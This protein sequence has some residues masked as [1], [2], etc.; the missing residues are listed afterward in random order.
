MDKVYWVYKTIYP[1]KKA[2]KGS[3]LEAHFEAQ[4][5][6]AW[7]LPNGFQPQSE[8]SISSVGDLINHDYLKNSKAT[9]YAKVSDLIFGADITMANLECPIVPKANKEFV[10]SVKA[11]PPLYYDL[12]NFAVVKGTGDR[13][14]SFMATACNHSL[15]FGPEGV[16]STIQAL[17]AEGIAYSGINRA[18]ED[19]TRATILK[20][21]GYTIGVVAFTFGLNGYKQPKD[22][23]AIVN[24]HPL[25]DGPSAQE[26]S[27]LKK[28]IAYCKSQNVDFLIAHLHWGMEHEFYP[29]PEQ[30]ELA[31]H[32][33]ELGVDAI[34]GHHPHVIQPFEFYRT[35]RDPLRVVPVFYSLG[36][37]VNYFTAP[38][39]C[40]SGLAH[41]TLAKGML[42]DGATR[43]Y[44]KSARMTEVVQEADTVNRQ[45]RLVPA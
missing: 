33:A 21:N 30:Q 14:Y 31:H 12:E 34:I 45:I 27:Q 5:S 16:D 35:R 24:I 10:F 28:Q 6:F 15:D 29:A 8:L 43:V 9:L 22:R 1:V 11:G 19:A 26:F 17:N 32:I 42:Q 38:Y 25:N 41:L 37:L 13:K 39:L 2:R 23:P 40:R 18:D 44:V 7:S 4:K 20:K 3:G 36:N